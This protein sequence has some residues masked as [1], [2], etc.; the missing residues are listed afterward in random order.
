M[1]SPRRVKYKINKANTELLTTMN[2][3]LIKSNKKAATKL[4][5]LLCENSF[6]II[7]VCE[8]KETLLTFSLRKVFLMFCSIT[9]N[10][11]YRQIKASFHVNNMI[12]CKQI[13]W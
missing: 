4:W 3:Y 11:F 6:S 13:I 1:S 7:E 10:L 2:A 5:P 9:R 8:Y 12:A